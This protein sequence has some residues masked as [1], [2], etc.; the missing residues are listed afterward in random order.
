MRKFPYILLP[1][2]RKCNISQ[3]KKDGKSAAQHINYSKV[4]LSLSIVFMQ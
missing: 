4:H 3:K 1:R 2:K